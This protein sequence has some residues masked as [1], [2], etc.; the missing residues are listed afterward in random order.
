MKMSLNLDELATAWFVVMD[1]KWTWCL[2]CVWIDN[3]VDRREKA[4]AAN[5]SSTMS[6]GSDAARASDRHLTGSTSA[7]AG[8]QFEPASNDRIWYSGESSP[9]SSAYNGTSSGPTTS[10]SSA[11]QPHVEDLSP[12]DDQRQRLHRA[13]PL[14]TLNRIYVT[15]YYVTGSGTSPTYG[16]VNDAYVGDGILTD[17]WR[18]VSWR[19]RL[20]AGI[21]RSTISSDPGPPTT[22]YEPG[23][24]PS[25]HRRPSY[26]SDVIDSVTFFSNAGGS[27][28][29]HAPTD[30]SV[31]RCERDGGEWTLRTGNQPPSLQVTDYTARQAHVDTYYTYAKHVLPPSDST[32]KQPA[33]S[34]VVEV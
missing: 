22:N 20:R 8:G 34:E 33:Y 17:S 7:S 27:A 4:A 21:A 30:T 29:A 26:L 12:D 5:K 3:V 19:A 24:A 15:D 6:C 1:C 25:C 16:V 2:T 31:V 28:S 23:Q 13:S 10:S 11:A 32:A 9:T 14:T 18:R